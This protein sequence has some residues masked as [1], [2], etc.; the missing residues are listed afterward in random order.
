[1]DGFKAKV[2]LI[3][4]YPSDPNRL[5]R[6]MNDDIYL[7]WEILQYVLSRDING[8]GASILFCQ[9]TNSLL[10]KCSKDD[11]CQRTD[12]WRKIVLICIYMYCTNRE[13]KMIKHLLYLRFKF[14]PN[15][16]STGY[17]QEA[18]KC[19]HSKNVCL[20]FVLFLTPLALCV[21]FLYY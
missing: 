9:N 7:I 18:T 2:N 10:W 17:K 21:L 16:A 14:K 19:R 20:W 12:S 15:N 6:K 5:V 1:M 4:L 13:L 11:K 3:F 8:Y